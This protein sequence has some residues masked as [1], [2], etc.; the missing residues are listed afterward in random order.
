M[1]TEQQWRC[2]TEPESR[3]PVFVAA[4]LIIAGQT[5]VAHSLVLR[6]VWV[7]PAISTVLLIAS[8]AVYEG[9]ETPGPPARVLSFVWSRS[10]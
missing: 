1:A 9:S 4:L 7:F 6:P 5:W 8:I 2:R 10:W 3:R